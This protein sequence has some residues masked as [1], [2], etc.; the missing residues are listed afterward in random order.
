ML[1]FT[2]S[3]FG[4]GPCAEYMLIHA[5]ERM[6]Q[7]AVEEN[8]TFISVTDTGVLL[9]DLIFSLWLEGNFKRTN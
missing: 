8:K 6:R 7:L 4:K 3:Y 9:M 2:T 1:F 5:F